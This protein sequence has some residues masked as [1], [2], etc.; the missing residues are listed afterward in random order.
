MATLDSQDEAG[1]ARSATWP[2]VWSIVHIVACSSGSVSASTFGNTRVLMRG[3]PW[4]P[5]PPP[6]AA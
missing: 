3:P 1:H 6:A 2:L 4:P 5:A